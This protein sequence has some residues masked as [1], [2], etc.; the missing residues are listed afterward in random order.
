MIAT[1]AAMLMGVDP[2]SIA[3]DARDI[4]GS[5]AP[6]GAD[7]GQGAASKYVNDSKATNVGGD[8]RGARL[9]RGQRARADRRIARRA[10]TSPGS[11]AAVESACAGGLSERRDRAELAAGA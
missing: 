10:R 3:G 11:K 1:Q 5:A 7:R 9:V 6:H 8:A 4:P 2:L